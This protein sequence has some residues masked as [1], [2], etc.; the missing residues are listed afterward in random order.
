MSNQDRSG[1]FPQLDLESTK[2]I[3]KQYSETGRVA[4]EFTQNG[5]VVNSDQVVMQWM[6]FFGLALKGSEL[7]DG[8][9]KQK[10]IMIDRRAAK[11]YIVLLNAVGG[12]FTEEDILSAASSFSALLSDSAK[13]KLPGDIKPSYG[14]N[15]E[16]QNAMVRLAQAMEKLK[17]QSESDT[18]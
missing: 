1:Y 9:N 10:T 7:A 18:E 8:I 11:S 2:S 4:P 16:T 12:N 15:P 3:L 14:I 6:N 17:Q 5:E 13:S